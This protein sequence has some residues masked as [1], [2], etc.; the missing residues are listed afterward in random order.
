M[1]LLVLAFILYFSGLM[2]VPVFFLSIFF[3]MLFGNGNSFAKSGFSIQCQ[4]SS[5]N[6]NSKVFKNIHTGYTPVCFTNFTQS[7]IY[8]ILNCEEMEDPES[9]ESSSRKGRLKNSLPG[10]FYNEF[11]FG[12]CH[13]C[14]KETPFL[15]RNSFHRYILQGT[16]RI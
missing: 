2:K 16:L 9:D 7:K 4:S 6:T 10:I 13:N 11:Y 5:I 8:E 3:L 12:Y 14:V 15:W 1:I